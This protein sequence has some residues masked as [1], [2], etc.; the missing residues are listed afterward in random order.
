MKTF[1]LTLLLATTAFAQ[2]SRT[3]DADRFKRVTGPAG[4]IITLP[5]YAGSLSTLDGAE[6][7]TN[8][9][10]LTPLVSGATILN[11]SISG[12]DIFASDINGAS[13]TGSVFDSGIVSGTAFSGGSITSTLIT[14][15]TFTGGSIS[16]ASITGATM[17][18]SNI[19]SGVF[20]IAR[21]GTNNGSLGVSAGT[22]LYMDGSKVVTTNV[23]S[24]GQI[25][26]ASGT[27]PVWVGMYS[28]Q[29]IA[30]LDINWAAA[31]SFTKTLAANSTFTFSNLESGK[32]IVVRLTNTASN[33][34][35]TWPNSAT[36]KWSGGTAPTMTVGAKSDVYTFYYDG[37]FVYG[38]YV[39]DF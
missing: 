35:V 15:T 21:G 1:L 22:V 5:N 10:I 30:A 8:K 36:L 34:T 24:N 23:P 28:V 19:T 33:Y 32:T 2:V 4:A 27:T 31:A 18:A 7:L 39:Q 12:T 20:P 14:L 37:T 29:S 38:S 3:I 11:G 6:T 17:D 9:T 16:G 13:I 26:A 25:L